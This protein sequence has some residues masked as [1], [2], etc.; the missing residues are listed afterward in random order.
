MFENKTIL[1]TGAATRLGKELSL[2]FA[3]NNA[4]TIII[5]YNN[6]ISSAYELQLDLQE[7]GC[8]S[9]LTQCNFS[10]PDSIKEMF[11]E[12]ST[13]VS[14]IDILINNASVFEKSK[15]NSVSASELAHIMN[16]NIISP[17]LCIQFASKLMQNGL[18][19]NLS[20]STINTL[21]VNFAGHAISKSALVT[22]MDLAVKTYSPNIRINTIVIGLVMKSERDT[23]WET[24]VKKTPLKRSGSV[25]DIF[26]TIVYLSHTTYTTGATIN[27]DGGLRV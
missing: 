21:P 11:N 16:V 8:H 22:M 27:V 10:Q 15:L 26:K 14:S 19:V 18:V 6:S 1:I 4:K 23:Q 25:E 12:I 3:K 7:L 9:I 13:Q 17:I 5:H 20:D 2:L 24:L